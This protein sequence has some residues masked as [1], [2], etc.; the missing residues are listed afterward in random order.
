MKD[1]KRADLAVKALLAAGSA[2]P[3]LLAAAA[4]IGIKTAGP[5]VPVPAPKKGKK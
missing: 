1:K 2:D 4:S 5:K 3:D